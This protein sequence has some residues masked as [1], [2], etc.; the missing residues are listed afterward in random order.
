LERF[1]SSEPLVEH[2]PDP[3][4]YRIIHPIEERVHVLGVSHDARIAAWDVV[5]KRHHLG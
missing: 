3:T 4:E 1:V 2:L 5:E